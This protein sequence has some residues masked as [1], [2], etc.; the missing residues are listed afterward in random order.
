M[1]K[2]ENEEVDE[3]VWE[4]EREK[5]KPDLSDWLPVGNGCAIFVCASRKTRIRAITNQK[6]MFLLE[7]LNNHS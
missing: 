6:M 2:I 3:S 5:K 1:N 4:I 7:K